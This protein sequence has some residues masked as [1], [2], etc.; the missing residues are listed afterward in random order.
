MKYY[1]FILAHLL[2]IIFLVNYVFAQFPLPKTKTAPMIDGEMEAVWDYAAR[3]SI[4]NIYSGEAPP[5][6]SDDFSIECRMLWD[7]ANIYIL[8]LVTDDII[9]VS[10]EFTAWAVVLDC[11]TYQLL[12]YPVKS[13]NRK[14]LCFYYLF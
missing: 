14:L 4:Q 3:D 13:L 11:R 12:K 9:N 10:N 7:N 6:N 5:S 8:A 2:L 1:K